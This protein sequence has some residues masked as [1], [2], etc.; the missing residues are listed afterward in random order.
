MCSIFH[1][2]GKGRR[3]TRR[4]DATRSL[5]LPSENSNSTHYHSHSISIFRKRLKRDN[6]FIQSRDK[7][8]SIATKQSSWWAKWLLCFKETTMRTELET[9]RTKGKRIS[10]T[11]RYFILT[12]WNR[13]RVVSFCLVLPSLWR[14]KWQR[15]T[16][17]D[18][19]LMQKLQ[20]MHWEQVLWQAFWLHTLQLT[21]LSYMDN[22]LG[23]EPVVL[24]TKARES[25]G[26]CPRRLVWQKKCAHLRG[27]TRKPARVTSAI[28]ATP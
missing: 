11:N 18:A 3:P 13:D 12:N 7:K 22:P 8:S 20:W 28:T 15:R 24:S 2:E 17:H 10:F 6:S 9:S 1:Q 23:G 14:F 4:L 5:H 27:R 26:G 25:H 19:P 21:E 16:T